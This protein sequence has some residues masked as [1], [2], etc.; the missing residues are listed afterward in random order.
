MGRCPC[1]C[2]SCSPARQLGRQDPM[3]LSIVFTRPRAITYSCHEA[4]APA[5]AAGAY[6]AVHRRTTL[7]TTRRHN[8]RDVRRSCPEVQPYAIY[9]HHATP[10]AAIVLPRVPEG[11][12]GT[13]CSGPHRA[14][15]ATHEAAALGLRAG[16]AG[17]T[18]R[19]NFIS[20]VWAMFHFPFLAMG[21]RATLP[22]TQRLF[23]RAVVF[24]A[25]HNIE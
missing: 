10:C 13:V 6:T 5:S 23:Q 17:P 15:R 12:V 18:W 25:K 22:N 16:P 20:V 21:C 8:C 2:P 19:E 24:A 3:H 9:T 1:T 4:Y 14:R 7:V 11:Q